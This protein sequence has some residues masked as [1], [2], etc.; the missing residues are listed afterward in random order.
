MSDYLHMRHGNDSQKEELMAL[1]N[2]TF[3]FTTDEEKFETLIPKLYNDEYHPAQNNIILDVNGEMRAAVGVYYGSFFVGDEKL[4]TAGIGNVATHPDYQGE[5]YMKFCMALAMDEIKQSMADIAM[6]GGARQR[7]AH[8]GFEH[9]G[10]KYEFTYGQENV[11]RK[12]F[13]DKK[14]KFTAKLI[15]KTDKD[16]LEKITEIYN[17]RIFKAERTTDT[18]YDILKTWNANPYAVFDG[19]EFK[20]WYVF[21]KET[22]CTFELG[23]VNAE[24]IEDIVISALEICGKKQFKISAAPFEIQLCKF[25]G[26]NCE[27][28]N[29]IHSEMYNIMCYENVIRAFLKLKSKFNKLNDGECVL[30]IEGNK[31]HEQI[32]IT[33]K[34][35]N[36]TVCETDEKP[37]LA[38]KHLDAM[39]L[40]AGLYSDRRNELPAACASWF[41]LPIYVAPSDTV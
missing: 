25:L 14:S 38:L 16:I 30:F 35:N 20:G 6:L 31:L 8:Y 24:D 22:D 41:P 33:V 13:C 17:S 26:L 29:I 2:K 27:N 5:G 1:L 4:K 9:G 18:M 34:D 21:N 10:A 19:V 39:R 37:D 36:V 23:F 12:F 7:Y 3:G 32:K 11:R 28:Y 40:V 15:E